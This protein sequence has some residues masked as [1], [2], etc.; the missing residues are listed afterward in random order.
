MKIAIIGSGNVGKA[1]ASSGT[2]AGHEVTITASDAEHAAAAAKATGARAGQSNTEAVKDAEIVI[3]AVPYDKLG[4]VF[5]G[6]G[7]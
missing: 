6:L 7:S 4:E 5:R 3:I 2:R 1:L